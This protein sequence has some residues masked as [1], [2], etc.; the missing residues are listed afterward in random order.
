MEAGRF[1]AHCAGCIVAF[2]AS[3]LLL[4]NCADP[5]TEAETPGQSGGTFEKAVN[6]Y[7]QHINSPLK[8]SIGFEESVAS[9]MLQRGFEYVPEVT[10]LSPTSSHTPR[11]DLT[12]AEFANVWG[13]GISTSYEQTTQRPSQ[14][15]MDKFDAAT[16]GLRSN[17]QIRAEL[18]AEGQFEWDF[19]LS[20][21]TGDDGV[22]T[23]GCAEIAADE[24]GMAPIEVFDFESVL[25]EYTARL[26]ADPGVVQAREDY[27][28]CFVDLGFGYSDDLEAHVSILNK[29]DNILAAAARDGANA[30][31]VKLADDVVVRL[32][33]ELTGKHADDLAKL[34][35]HEREVAA[36]HHG[37]LNTGSPS[38]EELKARIEREFTEEHSDLIHRVLS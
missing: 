33:P 18:S 34:Q 1:G 10:K 16:S 26:N 3:V 15:M 37:C 14:E 7:V 8:G 31:D 11:T 30:N 29:L 13:F 4:A 35:D 2:L 24:L 5:A 12:G 19:A 25:D 17:Q 36:G 20:G 23:D 28:R 22:K 32:N 27:S 6:A 9:C 38:L 21:I